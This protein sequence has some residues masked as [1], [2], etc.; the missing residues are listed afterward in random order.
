MQNQHGNNAVDH[1]RPLFR[2]VIP[3]VPYPNVFS[4]IAM[5]P[6]GALYVATCIDRAGT[7]DV[8]IIDELNW[9]SGISRSALK[10]DPIADHR[11]LQQRRPAHAVGFYG[12]L[13]STV[14]RLFSLAHFYNSQGLKTVAGGAHVDALPAEALCEGLDIVVHSEG[15]ESIVEIL[16]AWLG[17]GSVAAIK[18][19]SYLGEDGSL[20]TTERRTP[21]CNL[22]ELPVP[23]LGLLAELRRP[24]TIAPIERTRG[25]NFKCEFCV[26]N[27]RFGPCRSASP[28]RVAMEIEQRVDEGFRQ[29]FCVDD[30]FTQGKVDTLR[31]L[32]LIQNIE[33]RKKVKLNLTVQVRSS[34]ARDEETLV[35]MR[36]AGVQM[37]CIGLESP[38]AEELKVMSKAQTPEQIEKDI[39]ILKKHGFLIHG[40]FIFG[41]PLED[42]ISATKLTLRE[43]AD[44]Y[45]AFIKRTAIDTVQVLKPV[46]I[47][48]SRLAKRL[49]EQGRILPLNLVGWDKYDG[50]FLTFLP[51]FGIS[52]SELQKQATR[53]MRRFY[54][55]Y[56][57]LKFPVLVFDTP[58]RILKKGFQ[59]A[60][61]F[62]RDPASHTKAAIENGVERMSAFQVGFVEAGNE[63][64]RRWRNAAWRTLGSHVVYTWMRSSHYR[65]YI[66]TLNGLQS[67]NHTPGK[68]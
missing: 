65:A 20:H 27:D 32:G 68:L 3:R 21:I 44:R 47:P 4:H 19:I 34:V 9:R 30:N 42:D 1:E 37:L 12:G 52:A 26:V 64:A 16:D 58:V 50:N 31:L 11:D 56:S 59:N 63:I 41:Y 57:F 51:E 22:D 46:P 14:P 33:K 36:A 7:W 15:E 45:L 35:A 13:S 28:E 23:D 62:A 54:S 25:C 8:E 60:S 40:M 66:R 18:G 2:L 38:I 67:V 10:K 24:I 43:R 5:A 55:P 39:S 29:F 6:L 48:G 49:K 61:E 17:N 53:I